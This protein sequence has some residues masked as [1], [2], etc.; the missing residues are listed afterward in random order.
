[1]S[2]TPPPL[3]AKLKTRS[4][5]RVRALAC[6]VAVA[7]VV[8][9]LSTVGIYSGLIRSLSMS[10]TRSMVPTLSPGDHLFMEGVSQQFLPLR[11]GDVIAFKT[12]SIPDRAGE[13]W[14]LRVV[15]LPGDRLQL[16]DGTLY[17]NEAPTEF[18]SKRGAIRYVS[19][20]MSTHLR[21]N[22]EPLAV[23]AE[24]YFLLGDNSEISFDSRFWGCLPKQ[25]VLGRIWACYWPPES[26][27]WVRQSLGVRAAMK[28]S[29]LRASA[30]ADSAAA[31]GW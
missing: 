17:V 10:R 9:T 4:A 3:P 31:A 18:V 29:R 8:G 30:R 27:G 16:R 26:A 11:R 6:G 20:P 28:A 2:A 13:I 1:M 7:S 22:H 15:G 5:W 24:C 19:P 21:P 23:P 25:D 14:P 12:D